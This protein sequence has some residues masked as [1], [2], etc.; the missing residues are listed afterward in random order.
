MGGI[1]LHIHSSAS[2]GTLTPSQVVEAGAEM[3]LFALAI[4][5]HDSVSGI[6]E[7]KDAG[8]RLGITVVPG[9]EIST[10]DDSEEVHILGYF[11]DY[12]AGW[13]NKVLDELKTKRE[14]R[15]R[16]ILKKLDNLGIKLQEEDVRAAASGGSLGRPHVALALVNKGYVSSVLE[17]FR[18]YLANRAPAYVPR[19][20]AT[21]AQAVNIIRRAQG[22]AVLAHPAFIRDQRRITEYLRLGIQGIECWHSEQPPAV[23]RQYVKLAKRHGLVMTGGSDFHGPA[24]GAN[25]RLGIPRVDNEVYHQLR[26]FYLAGGAEVVNRLFGFIQWRD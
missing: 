7:A 15:I 6:A 5:D 11:V 25:R 2:D 13:F 4:T 26:A 24:F 8:E 19:Q 16:K 3:K 23:S 12:Q 22:L 20:H 21:P 9:L 18:R 17:A 1:D 14:E 10:E